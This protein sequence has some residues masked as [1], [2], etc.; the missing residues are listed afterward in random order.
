VLVEL[1]QPTAPFI[2]IAILFPIVLWLPNSLE[3]LRKFHPA[4]D[5]PD[6][7]EETPGRT[8]PSAAQQ[9]VE[10]KQSFATAK[11]LRAW[12]ALRNLGH[13]GLS[14]NRLSASIMAFLCV[15]GILALNRG[16]AF[17]YW[18]F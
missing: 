9:P 6:D 17:L 16:G 12:T 10:G 13:D 11:F 1:F 4:L 14:F 5:F 3:L 2:W 7:L 18:K 8:G 15:L